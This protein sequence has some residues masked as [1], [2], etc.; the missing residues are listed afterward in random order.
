MGKPRD[1]VWTYH[2]VFFLPS[3]LSAQVWTAWLVNY[4]SPHRLRESLELNLQTSQSLRREDISHSAWAASLHTLQETS[5]FILLIFSLWS[6]K[7]LHIGCSFDWSSQ[8]AG[9][10]LSLISSSKPRWGPEALGR[11]HLGGNCFWC[12]LLSCPR[13]DN[14]AQGHLNWTCNVV[15]LSVFDDIQR[16]EQKGKQLSFISG[17]GSATLFLELFN[18]TQ[19]CYKGLVLAFNISHT[20]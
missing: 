6:G 3:V 10:A 16:S 1:C 8:A 11:D 19:A 2:N 9:P 14:C 13:P 17:T 18:E 7:R 20:L 15:Q 5:F 4:Y 12:F